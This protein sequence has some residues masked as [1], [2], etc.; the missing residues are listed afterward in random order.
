MNAENDREVYD[1]TDTDSD[2]P[3]EPNGSDGGDAGTS[4]AMSIHAEIAEIAENDSD[5]L[6]DTST[7]E[8][9]DVIAAPPHPAMES[10]TVSDTT[11][12]A[13]ESYDE[14]VTGTPR[15]PLSVDTAQPMHPLT[16]PEEVAGASMHP[17]RRAHP[18]PSTTPSS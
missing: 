15:H 5:V 10:E 2:A 16:N 6:G 7:E 8:I 13:Q 1:V 14:K 18:Y 12:I 4:D 11:L 9:D 3:Q 17:P